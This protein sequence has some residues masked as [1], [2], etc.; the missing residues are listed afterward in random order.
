VTY[1]D[2]PA[3]SQSANVANSITE[4]AS[5]LACMCASAR[6]AENAGWPASCIA[7]HYL[8]DLKPPTKQVVIPCHTSTTEQVRF[9]A[10]CTV[11]AQDAACMGTDLWVPLSC[12]CSAG[13]PP[14]EFAFNPEEVSEAGQLSGAV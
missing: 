7:L 1:I 5:V 11:T 2:H 13:Q 9:S 8:T 3:E 12:F 10:V 14:P 6:V 4:A